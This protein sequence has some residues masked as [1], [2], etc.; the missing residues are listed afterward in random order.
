MTDSRRTQWQRVE[1]PGEDGIKIYLEA[2]HRGGR[3]QVGIIDSIPFEQV[4][5]ILVKIAQGIGDTVKKTQP[6]K[7][8]VE[9]G[10]EFALEGGQLVAL[11]ARGTGKANLKLGLEWEKPKSSQK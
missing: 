10:I 8:T 4:T 5:E 6:N 1:L 7:A 3:E 2:V 11:I 9:L